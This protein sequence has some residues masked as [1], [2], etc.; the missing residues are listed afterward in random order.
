MQWMDTPKDTCVNHIWNVVWLN[1]FDKINIYPYM[2]I[3]L[4]KIKICLCLGLF[5]FF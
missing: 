3:S 1:F 2:C 4:F 5:F